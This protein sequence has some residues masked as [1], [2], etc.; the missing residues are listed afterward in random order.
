MPTPGPEDAILASPSAHRPNAVSD[1]NRI[2]AAA[3]LGRP[4]GEPTR[5][6]AAVVVLPV[7]NADPRA[8]RDALRQATPADS[9]DLFDVE[10]HYHVDT[11]KKG[12]GHDVFP[13]F[14]AAGKKS[15]HGTV[16]WTEVPADEMPPAPPWPPDG[17][18]PVVA[19]LDSGVQPHPWLPPGAEPQFCVPIDLG[20]SVD[21]PPPA[22]VNK[23]ME[24]G[25]YWGH[26][27]F[28]SGLIRL[29]AP[30]AQVLSLRV[31]S[32][33]GAV[34]ESDVVTALKWLAHHTENGGVVDVVLMAFGRP[35]D[36]EDEPVMLKR[37]IQRL[38]RQGVK[39]VASAGN[40][41]SDVPT[42][43]AFLA[44]GLDSPVVSVGAGNSEAV[45]AP[46]SNHGYWVH[47]WR[48]GTDVV[49]I[50][51]LTL[52]DQHP[53]AGYAQWSGT[54]FSAAIYAGELAHARAA[55]RAA[56]TQP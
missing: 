32:I 20:P 51:P 44:E 17:A 25:R 34:R 55:E 43:P 19:V 35:R 29:T 46:Y 8:V 18:R 33:D 22:I 13:R 39:I 6:T 2:L 45:H 4:L 9:E 5:T 21:I 28:L 40:G 41:A 53:G 52:T 11:A 10:S 24:F 14:L 54:S 31:M 27:T 49:S 7:S 16:T 47:Q 30:D 38:G 36:P 50:M 26:A 48:C 3:G 15:G 23:T 56:G 12:E 37:W 42:I 1:F